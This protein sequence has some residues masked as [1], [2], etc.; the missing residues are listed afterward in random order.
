[1]VLH[2]IP[3]DFQEPIKAILILCEREASYLYNVG[4]ELVRDLSVKISAL[5]P[6]SI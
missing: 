5:V 6:Q 4:H 3:E 1:V 2:S